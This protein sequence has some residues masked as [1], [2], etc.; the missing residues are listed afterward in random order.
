MYERLSVNALNA[1]FDAEYA[2]SAGPG[3]RPVSDETF[4]MTPPDRSTI[5]GSTARVPATAAKKFVSKT[6]RYFAM[7]SPSGSPIPA[8]LTSRSMRPCAASRSDNTDANLSVSL[9]SHTT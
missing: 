3:A 8:S 9:T 6:V 5:P 4:T 2:G 7:P 1:A